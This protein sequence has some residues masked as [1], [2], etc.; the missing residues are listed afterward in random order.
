MEGGAVTALSRMPSNVYRGGERRG[1]AVLLLNQLNVKPV[2]THKESLV[3][4]AKHWKCI[5]SSVD[6]DKWSIIGKGDWNIDAQDYLD[7]ILECKKI[8]ISQRP[9]GLASCSALSMLGPTRVTTDPEIL[10]ATLTGQFN[11]RPG[12]VQIQN[13]ESTPGM[14]R[15]SLSSPDYSLVSLHNNGI[16][17][18]VYLY[19]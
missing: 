11:N 6:K 17:I 8:E 19:I 3:S 1:T 7:R 18:Y 12:G 13:W 14:A 15:C 2:T 9:V 5:I 10:L 16:Y 4:R